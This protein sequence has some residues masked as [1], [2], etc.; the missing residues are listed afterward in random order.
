[1]ID[2]YGRANTV[3][4]G[5]WTASK[6]TA[7]SPATAAVRGLGD[8]LI[9]TVVF[10]Q[11]KTADSTHPKA[12]LSPPLLDERDDFEKKNC[13]AHSE[14]SRHSAIIAVHVPKQIEK[15]KPA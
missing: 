5:R 8:A 1:M 9:L 6:T 3:V 2:E 13:L 14:I 15:M 7:R 4:V 10:D 11:N 12:A